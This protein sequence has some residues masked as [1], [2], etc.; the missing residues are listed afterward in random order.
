MTDNYIKNPQAVEWYLESLEERQDPESSAVTKGTIGSSLC[1][2]SDSERSKKSTMVRNVV[3]CLFLTLLLTYNT[4]AKKLIEDDEKVFTSIRQNF[5]CPCMCRK[6]RGL[7]VKDC[8]RCIFTL[9]CS[10]LKK[11]CILPNGKRGF[12]CCDRSG[13]PKKPK[14]CP[15]KCQTRQEAKDQCK[16]CQFRQCEFSKCVKNGNPGFWCCAP[17]PVPSLEA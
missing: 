3:F 8:Q 6:N 13:G 12:Q 17:E 16:L 10:V 15:C 11:K 7:A 14:K 1:V 4:Q 5:T 9:A 2:F